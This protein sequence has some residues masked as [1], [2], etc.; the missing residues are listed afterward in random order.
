MTIKLN[1]DAAICLNY[2]EAKDFAEAALKDGYYLFGDSGSTVTREWAIPIE[3][4]QSDEDAVKAD[5]ENAQKAMNIT[6][7]KSDPRHWSPETWGIIKVQNG[8]ITFLTEAN[9]Y[10]FKPEGGPKWVTLESRTS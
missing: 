3:G 4:I 8:Q 7:E 5:R 9:D 6:D 2:G 1:N 10:C